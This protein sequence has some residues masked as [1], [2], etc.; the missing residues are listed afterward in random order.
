MT[1][2]SKPRLGRGLSSLLQ[3]PVEV[4]A[5]RE[6]G[7]AI[8]GKVVPPVAASPVGS[9]P[10]GS[11]GIPVFEPDPG[12]QRM[13]H[14]DIATIVPGRF[15]PRREL[16]EESISRLA[17][18]IRA[19]GVM[20]PI[21]VRPLPESDSDT[22]GALWELV[23]GERRWRAAKAAGLS[24]VPAVVTSLS[25]RDAAEWSLVENLQREDLNTMDRAWGLKNLV[26]RFS[27]TH[28]EVADRV[29]LDRSTVANI[30]RLT[31]LEPSIQA[32]LQKGELSLGHGKALLSLAPGTQR[33]R[34][35]RLAADQ[36]WS[37]RRL[38]R[39]AGAPDSANTPGIGG[40]HA[41]TPTRA[42]AAIRD[43][44]RQLGEHLGTKARII[45]GAS[46]S[47][48]RIVLDFYSL[49]HF[50]GLMKSMGVEIRG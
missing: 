41:I 18:S 47:K 32:M 48:G 4:K 19:A 2:T 42:D 31:E 46:R 49:E 7:Y 23:A 39:A 40:T 26:A 8:D 43:L 1:T 27:L 36:G 50:D 24:T 38:E 37:V 10:D 14:L 35:A 45:T 25:D 30:I 13:R 17:A 15:Q 33:E 3:S 20:Q 21:A 9:L 16:S 34:T 11:T 12:D 22:R 44:E 6:S 28:A 5:K 29:G